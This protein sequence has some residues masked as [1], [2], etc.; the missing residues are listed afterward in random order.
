MGGGGGLLEEVA[1]C[2]NRREKGFGD[3][4]RGEREHTVIFIPAWWNEGR[5]GTEF[6]WR[7]K[8]WLEGIEKSVNEFLV[9]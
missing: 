8:S 4:L 2:R 3:P 5:A 6:S 7:G 1:W 9:A